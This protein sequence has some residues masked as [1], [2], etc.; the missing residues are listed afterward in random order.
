MKEI[1]EN[2]ISAKAV[3]LLIVVSA[4]GFFVDIY[5]IMTLGAVGEVSLKSIGIIDK[6]EMEKNI[7]FLLNLQMLG[8][9]IGGFIW[10]IIGDK[11]GRLSVLFGSITI[12]TIF[13]FLNAF[14]HDTTQYSICRFFVSL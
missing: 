8:M 5:D 13:T 4:L 11:Y 2:I 7:T 12:Y 6:A 10:G 1:K 9:L 3:N 14:V